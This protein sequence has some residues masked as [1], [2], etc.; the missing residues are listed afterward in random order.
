MQKKKKKT[1]KLRSKKLAEIKN[2]YIFSL[3][4]KRASLVPQP[5]GRKCKIP[6][7]L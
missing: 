4:L 3:I 6:M 1:K 2:I 5:R 7:D